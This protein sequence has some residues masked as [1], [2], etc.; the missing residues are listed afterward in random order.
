METSPADNDAFQ[1]V[2]INDQFI[3]IDKMPGISFHTENSI[4]GVVERVKA[5]LGID[6]LYPVHRLDK[7]T[8]GLL[9]LARTPAVNSALSELFRS[10]K[11]EKYYLAISDR[12]PNK[13]QGMIKGDMVRSRRS[14]WKLTKSQDNPA[15]TQFFSTSIEPGKRLF[16]VRPKT[17]KTHQI[18]VALN[19]IGAPIE[20]DPLYNTESSKSSIRGYLHA[21]AIKFCLGGSM[22]QFTCK[23]TVGD[24]FLTD[25][26]QTALQQYEAPWSLSW[27]AS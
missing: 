18:R 14:S 24:S 6:E 16:L 23:P 4:L 11:V 8:S 27:P 26:F 15:I 9:I 19:S 7:I 2:E 22:Y 12:K 1:L 25:T 5:D 20:G 17:G 3:V 10:R 13:K 21:Y